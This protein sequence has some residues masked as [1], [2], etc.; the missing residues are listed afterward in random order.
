M[1]LNEAQALA[2]VT[3]SK[4]RRSFVTVLF[5][6]VSGSSELAESLDPE[7]FAAH[8]E[9]L[10]Y[11]ARAIIPRHGGSIARM[12]GD[13]L[14]ALFGQVEALEDDGR[15]AVEAALEL[16]QAVA[17]ITVGM[18]ASAQP[19]QM[20]SGIHAGL[21]LLL[22]GDIERGRYDVVGEVPNTAARLCSLAGKGE[23]LVSDET[24]GPQAPYFHLAHIRQLPIRGRTT[25]I[26]VSRVEG[27][28]NIARRT[29]ALVGDSKA[30]CIGREEIVQDLLALAMLSRTSGV[31]KT[32]LVRG[33]AGIG[34][35]RVLEEFKERLIDDDFKI[36][37][38]YCENYLGAQPLQP[39]AQW[40]RGALG[41]RVEE[42][43]EANERIALS[44]LNE[45]ARE[46]YAEFE[47]LA[48]ALLGVR[49]QTGDATKE[50][51]APNL[52]VSLAVE[53]LAML[54][55]QNPLILLLDDWQW[56]DDASRH[57]LGLLRSKSL[58]IFVLLAS[59]PTQ[60]D[61]LG[62]EG[63]Q[64][65]T[66][67]AL[68]FEQSGR[69]IKAFFPS[70][71]P[72]EALEI[73]RLSGGSPLYMQELCHAAKGGE[74]IRDEREPGVAWLNTLVASRVNRLPQEQAHYLQVASV[75]G[76][77]FAEWL[78]EK[79]FGSEE[80]RALSAA[81]RCAARARCGGARRGVAAQGRYRRA[82][83]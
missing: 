27:R 2:K 41:M 61:E 38:G 44:K 25:P 71:N 9:Q 37:Q 4:G 53:F 83:R 67:S 69:A 6:D 47:P 80:S 5:S 50:L 75:I 63:I 48:N 14:L 78:M 11:F 46:R 12:Q 23:V 52:R 26:N 82:R 32:A 13:G 42:N 70:I 34:K 74:L 40:L 17:T 58:P 1:N 79:I 35:T 72:L 30:T 36:L 20:H 73:Y 55:Q 51:V 7:E 65:F 31:G 43:Q 3:T 81:L 33:E 54:A 68:D 24:L 56:I 22:D 57:A 10:R 62:M 64:L 29:D 15:R 66:L 28:T 45:I 49:V 76:M 59:R 19:M 18:G 39:V 60:E 8:L 21:V 77:V 16:H